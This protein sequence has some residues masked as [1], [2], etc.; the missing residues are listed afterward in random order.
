MID[1]YK[2]KG[3]KIICFWKLYSLYIYKYIY[4]IRDPA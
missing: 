4:V 3:V 1:K 2:K